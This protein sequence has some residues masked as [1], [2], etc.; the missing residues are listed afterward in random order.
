MPPL[1]AGARRSERRPCSWYDQMIAI[2]AALRDELRDF[3]AQ[4]L[5]GPAEVVSGV[6]F[7]LSESAPLVVVVEGGVGRRSAQSAAGT[8]GRFRPTLIASVGFAG[9][10]S[11]DLQ[12]SD[13]VLC[14]RVLAVDGPSEQWAPETACV[15]LATDE[16][17]VRLLE[18]AAADSGVHISRGACLSV[19]ELVIASAHKT[20]LGARFGVNV[21]DMESYWVG[22]A[23]AELSVPFIAAR[24]ILD[25]VEQ[26]LPSSVVEL[27]G[28][29]NEARWR[30]AIRPVLGRPHELPALLRLARQTKVA[31]ASLTAL[32]RLV[33][34]TAALV[35]TG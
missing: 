15:P 4:G 8:V 17:A 21:I 14:D 3:L 29:P 28:K 32:L 31:R 16:S 18:D 9:G 5:F 20:E 26:S 12:T 10:A 2:V 7:Y 11:L 34:S 22:M 27:I 1:S 24:C 6:R 35:P 19:P 13:I 30:S 25:P 33:A 23:A